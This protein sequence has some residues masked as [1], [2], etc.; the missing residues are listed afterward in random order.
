MN[1]HKAADQLRAYYPDDSMTMEQYIHI[2][3]FNV[4]IIHRAMLT[5]IVSL[6]DTITLDPVLPSVGREAFFES[7][8]SMPFICSR[9]AFSS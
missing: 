5:L 1:L 9:T 7:T 8:S 6:I 2:P 3:Q 4:L